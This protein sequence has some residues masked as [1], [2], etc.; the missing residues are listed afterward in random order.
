MRLIWLT[1][2]VFA[3]LPASTARADIIDFFFPSLRTDMDDPSI[4][5]R[6][7][8]ADG[9]AGENAGP[10]DPENA[11]G[12]PTNAIPLERRHRNASQ[13]SEWLMTS[14]SEIMSFKGGPMQKQL[15]EKRPYFSPSGYQAFLD[16]LR[17]NNVLS[18]L[19]G[20]NVQVNTYVENM[21]LLLNEGP[22]EGRYR[23][24]Y[25]VPVVMTFLDR[26]TR[27]YKDAQPVNTKMILKIQVGRVSESENEHN[28]LVERISAQVHDTQGHISLPFQQ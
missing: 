25:E 10:A 17:Q 18:A 7:P 14:T 11:A 6:A 4:T 19:E 15:A 20:E 5:L 28:I 21:P 1:L 24:L 13:I 2:M 8:F 26:G 16:L 3:I 22:L 27:T 23:W 12:L 9:P